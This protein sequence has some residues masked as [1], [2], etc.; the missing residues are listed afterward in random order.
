MNSLSRF[1]PSPTG[2]I[3]IG[4]ARS[5]VLNW[6]YINNKKGNFILRIDDTDLERSK[7]EY[8]E[9]IKR[10]LSWLGISWDKSFNQS[11]RKKI[12]NQSIEKLKKDNRLYP[13]FE[14][15]EE[16]SLKKKSQL[17]SGK[18]PIYDRSS[19]YLT[20]IEIK[21]LLQSGKKPHWRFK[22]ENKTIE[23]ND[24]IKGK[25]SFEGKNLSDPVLIREDETLLYHLPSVI[26]DIEEG[27]SEIIRGEDHISNTAFHIQIFEALN[28]AIPT[29]GHHP[30]LTDENG[31]GFGKRLGSLSIEKLRDTG[32]ESL[33]I[34][35]YLLS[36]GTSSNIS[37]ETDLTKLINNYNISNISNSS[38]KFSIEVL[39]LLNKEILQKYTYSDVKNKFLDLGIHADNDFW[40]FVKNNINFFSECLEWYN[41]IKTEKSFYAEDKEFLKD[42]ADL[43]PKEP[44]TIDSWDEWILEINKKTGKKGKDLFMPLRMALTGKAKGPEL[45]FLI[46]LLTK[47]NIMKKLGVIT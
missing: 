35:N 7:K 19:L 37:S 46:P 40:I 24:L 26:D 38:P 12:Y 33:T 45:K 14:S 31:K 2:L 44:Y 27:V 6:A 29:F 22:L 47:N 42:A 15:Q 11:D 28:S 21:N 25:I 8:E 30:F 10:D 43:L 1:A 23:W 9:K 17:T 13:C 34:L 39:K 41:I 32:F 16:L 20:E 5:A 3:H 36:I 4:N 18:P